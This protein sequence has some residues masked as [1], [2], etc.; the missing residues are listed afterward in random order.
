MSELRRLFDLVC[1]LPQ[2]Q[3]ED[4]LRAQTS[5]AQ[6]IGEVLALLDADAATRTRSREPVR[7]MLMQL[8]TT[9]LHAGDLLGAWRLVRETGHGGMGA[10]YLAE[11]AD[12]HFQQRAAVKLIR[13]H[14]DKESSARFARERQLLANLQHPQ[15]A[16]LLD[17][18]STP[19]GAPYLV[20]EYVEGV[21]LDEWCV[22]RALDERLS[23]FVSICKTLQFAH[24][25][26][27]VHC[28][29]KPSNVLV[30]KD[31][32]PV[33][34]DFG[35]AQALD[36]VEGAAG[37]SSHLTP[38]Y[39]SPEQ[40]HGETPTVLSD[41]YALGLLLYR[42]CADVPPPAFD[43]DDPTA[44]PIP[45][46]ASVPWR[47]RLRGDLDAIVAHACA[48]DP[49]QR[50]AAAIELALD[51][52]RVARHEPVRARVP[53]PLY[54]GARLLRRRWPAFAAAA[55][56]LALGIGVV[57]QREQ[58][59]RQ[60]VLQRDRAEAIVR[61]TQSMFDES[62]A[63]RERGNE[64]TIREMLD[65]SSA[66]LRERGDLDP[67]VKGALLLTMAGAYNG[68]LLGKQAE[69]LLDAA[70]PLLASADL[71]LRAQLASVQGNALLLQARFAPALAA[72][73]RAAALLR[74]LPGDHEDEITTLRV[75]DAFI[76]MELLDVPAASLVTELRAIVSRLDSAPQRSDK[77]LL[78]ALDVLAHCLAMGG[79]VAESLPV[80]ERVAT[81]AE[82]LYGASDLR[83]LRL[84]IALGVALT[85]VDAE[86]GAAYFAGLVADYERYAGTP[87]SPFVVMLS[88]W[89]IA[90]DFGGHY[91][92]AVPVLERAITVAREVE[93]DTRSMQPR[94]I[95]VVLG[96]VYNHAAMPAKALGLLHAAMP[97]FESFAGS[98]NMADRA[99]LA[100]VVA[101]LGEAERQSGRLDE[102]ARQV[103]RAD[104]LWTK[105]DADFY[106]D[107]L[108][109]V[110]EWLARLR[111]DLRD[112][113]GAR[114]ALARYDSQL[115][116]VQLIKEKRNAT[117]R[118]LHARLD[119]LH[120]R[121]ATAGERGESA[122]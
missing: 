89:G 19:G 100:M 25:Q 13:G 61:F 108:L 119:V 35:I 12:G 10:V 91:A 31:G 53:T 60:V 6:M 55:L 121:V 38:R 24:Q 37:V 3:R 90:L 75:R 97:D 58:Q 77:L 48:P 40:V 118:E 67:E 107:D 42:L 56:L 76:H 114:T 39:A 23:I 102:A 95:T 103:A 105:V 82:R 72:D 32:G 45:S 14:A 34:L 65:R 112:D 28:D 92:Q 41:V 46:T 43:K 110:L 22:G 29:L 73:E 93:G 15:I 117:S 64:A 66:R 96:R 8:N 109:D 20:M 94:M 115:Q 49:A 120:A 62:S 83:T 4:A 99:A 21:P 47:R 81:L 69:P 86:R 30:R 71:G 70:V 57:A 50:Y 68:L 5:D 85:G 9:E 84:R 7:A 74:S 36:L 104:E 51:V 2:E 59:R 113:A 16:R 44:P 27:I 1:D 122:L 54:V 80:S 98:G 78:D 52:E 87:S 106:K 79:D 116:R 18:G 101:E 63:L 88:N 17:G 26:L 11:R 33:L 111:L